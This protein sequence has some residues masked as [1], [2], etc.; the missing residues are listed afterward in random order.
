MAQREL[1]GLKTKYRLY[2]IGFGKYAHITAIEYEEVVRSTN[3]MSEE[4]I[5][6]FR[7]IHWL[8]HFLGHYK[9]SWQLQKYL[10][11]QQI[12]P[13]DFMF[14]V[15]AEKV[16]AAPKVNELFE[17]LEQ[18]ARDEWFPTPQALVEYYSKPEIFEKKAKGVFGK[19]N[20]KYAYI[21]LL[22]AREEFDAHV[23]AVAKKLLSEKLTGE[24]LQNSTII[25]DNIIR[26]AREIYVE[27]DDV[28][29]FLSE[30]KAVFN[31]DVYAWEKDDYKKQLAAFVKPNGIT[32]RFYLPTDQQDALGVCLKQFDHPNR[33]VALRK[34]SEHMRRSDLFYR[35]ETL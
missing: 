24:A 23:A 25:V 27:F 9:Y 13:V 34:M 10:N 18:E 35:V 17:N 7:P 20:Q 29:I 22:T 15:L 32:Y 1:H 8:I 19:L 21:V 6:W 16:S 26:Y 31:Y 4:E 11:S 12:H 3:T 5:L 33:V 28:M 14:R 2:D 30:K